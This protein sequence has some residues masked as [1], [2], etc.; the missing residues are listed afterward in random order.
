MYGSVSLLNQCSFKFL[1]VRSETSFQ[2][3]FIQHN[4]KAEALLLFFFEEVMNLST[5]LSV[6]IIGLMPPCLNFSFCVIDWKTKKVNKPCG[7]WNTHGS[8]SESNNS[9]LS[10]IKVDIWEESVFVVFSWLC[11]LFCPFHT[12]NDSRIKTS[13]IFKSQ[14]TDHCFDLQVET[15]LDLHFKTGQ[16]YQCEASPN[17][18]LK[19]GD[20]NRESQVYITYTSKKNFR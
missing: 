8:Q 15:C 16:H 4:S 12:T 10:F 3:S 6:T 13:R 1:K 17:Y 2:T 5:S 14:T 11:R 19:Y 20:W 18:T 7:I 9:F